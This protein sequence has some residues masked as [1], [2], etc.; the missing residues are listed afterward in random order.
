[1]SRKLSKEEL[2]ECLRITVDE[3]GG[4]I[5]YYEAF[6]I[7]SILYAAD[8][9]SLAFERYKVAVA[10][11]EDPAT[12]VALVQEALTHAAALSRF[13]WPSLRKGNQL[14]S[15]RGKKLR[16]AFSLEDSSPLSSRDVRNA[17]EHFDERLDSF[18]LPERFGYF[19]P[20]PRIGSH[21]LA[22]EVTG[23]IFKL[24]DPESEIFVLLGQ[25]FEFGPIREAVF[26][27]YAKAVEM[28]GD[29]ERLRPQP[30]P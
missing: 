3:F 12:I 25:K 9:A 11:M 2:A 7:H 10:D 30:H 27:I 8:R 22:D 28:I 23:N 29:G 18:L 6:Y 19:F 17:I 21:E 14:A 5:P 4:I 24:V 26:D 16:Q 15:A 13:F 1:V 20:T